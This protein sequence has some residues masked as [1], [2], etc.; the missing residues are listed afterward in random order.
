MATIYILYSPKTDTYYVG[1]TGNLNDRL[2]RH[3][4]GRSTYT[5]RGI[6]WVI[7]YEKEY[8]TKSEAYQAEMYI[9]SQKS[10]KY[11]EDLIAHYKV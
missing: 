9:K 6:P 10:R 5:K 2:N 11:I 4:T 8:D 3:N 7:V 1:S